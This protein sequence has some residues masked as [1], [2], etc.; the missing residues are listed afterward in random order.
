MKEKT[1]EFAGECDY[2]YKYDILF[3]K[4]KGRQYLKSIELGN[5]IIDLDS[6]KFLNGI[7]VLEASKFLGLEREK[8]REI[9]T[10]NFVGR[11]ED[12]KIEV[13]LEFQ[14]KSRNLIIEKNSIIIQNIND[15]LP[16]SQIVCR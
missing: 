11:I 13:R 14:V 3:F 6:E 5:L 8:L 10:W 4:V 1:L 12:N 2:D 15:D 16:N 9:L 7:Q